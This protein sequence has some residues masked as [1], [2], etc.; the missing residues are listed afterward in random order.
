[1]CPPN[2][3]A[4]VICPVD[5]SAHHVT[6]RRCEFGVGSGESAST[7]PYFLERLGGLAAGSA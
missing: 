6:L 5:V 3:A 1:V 2:R 4:V 7:R